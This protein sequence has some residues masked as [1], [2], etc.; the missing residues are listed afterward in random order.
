MR[1]PIEI[2]LLPE[3]EDFVDTIEAS[4]R[5]KIF[6]AIRKTKMRVF[7]NW[8]KKLKKSKDIFEFRV[9]DSNKFFRLFAFWDSTGETET[10][11]VC[12][13]GLIKKSNKTP[14]KEIEK[15]EKIKDKYFKGLI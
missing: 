7:G 11:I 10:L 1:K 5:K 13:H 12:T 3:A 9:K 6:Y 4:A 14:K 15:A 2:I 8:F